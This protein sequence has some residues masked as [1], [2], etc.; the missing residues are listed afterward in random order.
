M[1]DSSDS[2]IAVDVQLYSSF[3]CV[4]KLNVVIYDTTAGLAF[5]RSS[6]RG[7]KIRVHSMKV[8]VNTLTRMAGHLP[9]LKVSFL[10]HEKL[11]AYGIRQDYQ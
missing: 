1:V 7:A 5:E 6:R 11:S 10:P 8:G 9:Q 2:Q 3:L 4:V